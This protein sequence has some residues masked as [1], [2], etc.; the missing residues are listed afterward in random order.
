ML[1]RLLRIRILILINLVFILIS[2][3]QKISEDV[4]VANALTGHWKVKETS[5]DITAGGIDMIQYLTT[6]FGY[7]ADESQAIYDS[8]TETILENTFETI[9]FDQEKIFLLNADK[10]DEEGGSWSVSVDGEMLFLYF[11]YEQEESE[12]IDITAQ[13][14]ILKPS[15]KYQEVDFDND[16]V[17]ETTLEINLE[18]N[19]SKSSNGGIGG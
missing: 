19:L 17:D 9:I 4:D 13:L 11:E 3:C 2:S 12:I 6:N 7:S 15:T 10:D 14:L 16:G 5:I 1:K 8:L 18:Q